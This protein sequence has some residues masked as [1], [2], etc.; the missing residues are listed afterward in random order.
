[1]EHLRQRINAGVLVERDSVR[2]IKCFLSH[3]GTTEQT[4]NTTLT[5]I[6]FW[7]VMEKPRM[8]NKYR[9]NQIRHKKQ[10]KRMIRLSLSVQRYWA[11]Y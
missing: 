5:N 4:V 7:V 8:K 3:L 1:M 11:V 10:E 9:I 2:K 6:I